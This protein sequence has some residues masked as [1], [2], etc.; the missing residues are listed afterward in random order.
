MPRLSQERT[1]QKFIK[2]RQGLSYK[3][4]V[5][6]KPQRN[7]ST[8]NSTCNGLKSTIEMWYVH[9]PHRYM[10]VAEQEECPMHALSTSKNHP[11]TVKVK[12]NI[13]NLQ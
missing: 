8:F 12:K 9:H 1:Q 6:V 13:V 2:R 4:Q 3:L 10:N 11:L 7:F 5:L